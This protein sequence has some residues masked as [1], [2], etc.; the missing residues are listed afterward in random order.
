M[1]MMTMMVILMMFKNK[2][3]KNWEKKTIPYIYSIVYDTFSW[4]DT[5]KTIGKRNKTKRWYILSLPPVCY[6]YIY[7]HVFRN[8]C[9]GQIKRTI[10]PKWFQSNIII[11]QIDTN[12]TE[13]VSV[14]HMFSI[15]F[16]Q[17][18]VLRVATLTAYKLTSNTRIGS[19]RYFPQMWQ[20]LYIHIIYTSK[21][22]IIKSRTRILYNNVF[23]QR[24]NTVSKANSR[25]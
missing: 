6:S 13:N 10:M 17:V 11:C 21:D 19:H 14:S 23:D 15:T 4:V 12:K 8:R 1:L 2:R 16:V 24:Y 22:N 3:R 18:D 9:V 20:C 25:K 7:I 5:Q